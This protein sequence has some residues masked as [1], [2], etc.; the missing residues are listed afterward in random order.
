MNIIDILKEKLVGK[1]LVLGFGKFTD[2][3]DD[4]WYYYIVPDQ[5][6][7]VSITKQ[8]FK[9]LDVKCD[10]EL[11][12]DPYFVLE[13]FKNPGWGELESHMGFCYNTEFEIEDV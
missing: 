8:S 2:P 12:D 5:D 1:Y 7:L 13:G 4:Y 11:D 3:D 9:I 10:G 6:G